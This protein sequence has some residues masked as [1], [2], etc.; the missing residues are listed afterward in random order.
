[1]TESREVSAPTRT[2]AKPRLCHPAG[3]LRGRPEGGGDSV[4]SPSRELE[5]DLQ[6]M[7]PSSLVSRPAARVPSAWEAALA[8][9]PCQYWQHLS[10]IVI[11]LRE[12]ALSDGVDFFLLFLLFPTFL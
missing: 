2:G 1:M 8:P 7:A 12:L 4:S 6:V 9:L 3:A 5:G 10:P 11:V